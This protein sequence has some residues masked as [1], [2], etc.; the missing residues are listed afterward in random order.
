MY[1]S[2]MH[3][4]IIGAWM[5]WKVQIDT[6][7]ATTREIMSGLHHIRLIQY[8]FDHTDLIIL[9]VWQC[10]TGHVNIY[11]HFLTLHMIMYYLILNVYMS[12][13]LDLSKVYRWQDG[14]TSLTRSS[15]WTKKRK[16]NFIIQWK[17]YVFD[18]DKTL[19]HFTAFSSSA[20]SKS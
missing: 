11:L 5:V 1:S 16:K 17:A 13:F 6:F 8:F 19:L 18:R 15:L 3:Y 12:R 9:Y 14:T 2:I 10:W 4:D 20:S 7:C